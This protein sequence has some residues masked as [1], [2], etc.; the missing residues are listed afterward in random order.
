MK[1][2]QHGAQRPGRQAALQATEQT[3]ASVEPTQP[4]A[5]ASIKVRMM[6]DDASTSLASWLL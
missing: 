3:S 5:M 4:D 1:V 2:P 6:L